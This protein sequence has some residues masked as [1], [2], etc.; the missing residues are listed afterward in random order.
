MSQGYKCVLYTMRR[1][2]V[3]STLT[4]IYHVQ[5]GYQTALFWLLGMMQQT[6]VCQL[7]MCNYYFSFVAVLVDGKGSKVCIF[8]LWP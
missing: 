3:R 4:M 7:L 6:P 5:N 1:L 2:Y 8:Y